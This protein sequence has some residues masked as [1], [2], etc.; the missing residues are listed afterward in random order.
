MQAVAAESQGESPESR[1]IREQIATLAHAL[2]QERGC[3]EDSSE[4]DWYRAEHELKASDERGTD[5][6][7]SRIARIGIGSISALGAAMASEELMDL[8]QQFLVA[9]AAHEEAR[10]EMKDPPLIEELSLAVSESL[11]RLDEHHR[12]PAP[13]GIGAS[14]TPAPSTG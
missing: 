13:A 12:A 4:V 10:T 14:R 8:L 2:W 6:L 3:P 5:R 1:P 11:T 9:A 7:H